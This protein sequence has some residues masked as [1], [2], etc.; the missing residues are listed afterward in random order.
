MKII[1]HEKNI[2]VILDRNVLV[3]RFNEWIEITQKCEEYEHRVK[4]KKKKKT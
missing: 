3:A 1:T 4:M 2:E